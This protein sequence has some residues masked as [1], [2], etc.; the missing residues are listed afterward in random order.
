MRITITMMSNNFLHVL[1]ESADKAMS[2]LELRCE[3]SRG[4]C[5]IREGIQPLVRMWVEANMRNRRVDAGEVP[6]ESASAS[7]PIDMCAPPPHPMPHQ[8]PMNEIPRRPW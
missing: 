6:C 3:S 8:T 7:A 2:P 1:C 5:E 4:L